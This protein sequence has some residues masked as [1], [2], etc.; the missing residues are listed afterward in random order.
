MH[1][2]T[3]Q[4]MNPWIP[5]EVI[6]AWLG[7]AP[8]APADSR[9]TWY[10]PPPNDGADMSLF[11]R[12]AVRL[13]ILLL[14]VRVVVDMATPQSPGAFRLDPDTS[15]KVA[16][17]LHHTAAVAAPAQPL[18]TS[19][20]VVTERIASHRTESRVAPQVRVFLPLT[21][22]PSESTGSPASSDDD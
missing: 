2:I 20:R 22:H 5:R 8:C 19:A 17:A 11:S 12:S 13:G 1:W 16:S 9:K 15:V 21:L 14:A 7:D 10:H 18:R 3:G 6:A 4:P